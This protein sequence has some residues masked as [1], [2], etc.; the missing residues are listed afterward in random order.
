[1]PRPRR[2]SPDE[3]ME[4]AMWSR[5]DICRI[6]RKD[7]RTIDRFINHPETKRRLR[8]YMING[9]FMAEKRIVLDYF[10]YSPYKGL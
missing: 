9:E 4:E 1:M 6:F 3:L 5:R 7:P 2:K 8:G 10:K